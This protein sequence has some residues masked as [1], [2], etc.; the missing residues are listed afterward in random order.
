MVAFINDHRG[1]YGVEPMCAVLPFA[2]STYLRRQAEPIFRRV[3]AK[4]PFWADQVPRL[5]AAG[6]LPDDKALITRIVKLKLAR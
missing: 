5:P 6:Q 2:P 4:E 1:Q 3:V